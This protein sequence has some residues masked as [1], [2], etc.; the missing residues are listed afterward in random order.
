ML[1]G[2]MWRY[3]SVLELLQILTD[4]LLIND[5]DKFLKDLYSKAN[6]IEIIQSIYTAYQLTGFHMKKSLP[7]GIS[8]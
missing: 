3:Y 1:L 2:G 7:R 8:D 4:K 6:H 5:P